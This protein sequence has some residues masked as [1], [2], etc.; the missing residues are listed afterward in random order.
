MCVV[1]LDEYFASIAATSDVIWLVLLAFALQI[2]L[3]AVEVGTS[4]FVRHFSFQ[5]RR[6]GLVGILTHAENFE[7]NVLDARRRFSLNRVIQR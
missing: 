7:V 1:V 6:G 2:L 3:I 5:L 4:A